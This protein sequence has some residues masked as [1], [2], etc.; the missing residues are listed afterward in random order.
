M[1]GSIAEIQTRVGENKSQRALRLRALSEYR[2][3]G[4][5]NSDE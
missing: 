5:L 1:H 3:R 4:V 2:T